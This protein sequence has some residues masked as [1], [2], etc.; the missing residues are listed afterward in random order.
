MSSVLK[1]NV[2][3]E[4]IKI[5]F[6]LDQLLYFKILFLWEHNIYYK[7]NRTFMH[8]LVYV[9]RLIRDKQGPQVVQRILEVSESGRNMKQ[10]S[11]LYAYAICARSNDKDTKKAAYA[12]ISR[13]CRIPTFL[14]MFIKFCEEES[15]EGENIYWLVFWLP[16]CQL[17][18]W[19]FTVLVYYAIMTDFFIG[20]SLKVY[21]ALPL[22]EHNFLI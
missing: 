18:I 3:A 13:I 20:D 15:S 17:I 9:H 19:Q 5:L 21:N 8:V 2:F 11:L 16:S 22:S 14:F 4:L 10:N 6:F 7:Y 1:G 12:V